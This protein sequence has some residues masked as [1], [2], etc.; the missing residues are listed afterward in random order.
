MTQLTGVPV[1]LDAQFCDAPAVRLF[2]KTV[3]PGTAPKLERRASDSWIPASARPSASL[4]SRLAVA[5]L[6]SFCIKDENANSI[7]ATANMMNSAVI[8]AIPR[9]LR[10]RFGSHASRRRTTAV[11]A[12]RA[13][14]PMGAR[15]CTTGL[16]T[17]AHGRGTDASCLGPMGARA[18]TTGLATT[19]HGRGTDASCL[20]PM[21]ARA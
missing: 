3:P 21:G 11:E 7:I 14:R 9:S 10:A 20:G 19:A 1:E 13:F 2:L 17:T 5:N 8:R 16:A 15:A 18:C 12:K 4:L 6:A